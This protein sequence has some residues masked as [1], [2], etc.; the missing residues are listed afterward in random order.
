MGRRRGGGEGGGRRRGG[1]KRKDGWERRGGKEEGRKGGGEEGWRNRKGGRRKGRGRDGVGLEKVQAKGQ[2]TCINTDVSLSSS[3]SPPPHSPL[4]QVSYYFPH[5]VMWR[6]FFGALTAAFTLHLMNP[7]FSGRLVLFYANY[8]HQWH[9]FEFLP[10][11]LLGVFGV[12]VCVERGGV[13]GWR[14]SRE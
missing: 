4:L 7:Y 6:A 13:W 9:L 14:G 10:F 11:I 8:D 5:K 1:E 2:C 3:I 12:S